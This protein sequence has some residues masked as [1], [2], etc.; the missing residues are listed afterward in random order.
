M[1]KKDR[2][3]WGKKLRQERI[4]DI[5]QELF[6][7]LGYDNT[8]IDRVADNAGYCKRTLYLY[9]KDKDDLF[10]AIVLRGLQRLSGKLREAY[11]RN[12]KGLDKIGAMADAYFQFYRED[13]AA[14][15]FVLQF[16]YRN[17]YYHKQVTAGSK[18]PFTTECQKLGDMNADLA[19]SAFEAAKKDGSI[20]S[21]LGPLQLLLVLW[22]EFSGVMRMIATRE[23]HLASVYGTTAERVFED[24]KRLAARS[25]S[26]G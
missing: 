13:P 26:A 1:K 6:S 18:K 10:A 24:F 25:L 9:F 11:D 23:P 20:R 5:A 12:E 4:I 7:S 15:D 17:R 22:G 16:D 14:F 19:I 21:S 3:E 8:T 2:K